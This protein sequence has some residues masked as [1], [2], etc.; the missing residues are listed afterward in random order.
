MTLTELQA[1]VMHQTNNDVDDLGD[2]TPY[3]TGYLNEGYDRLVNVYANAHAG[4]EGYP[5][6]S[7]GT[8]APQLP[9]WTHPAIANW[10]TWLIYRNGNPNKQQRGLQ[11]RAA[12]EEVSAQV[13]ASGGLAGDTARAAGEPVGQI[14]NI[15]FAPYGNSSAAAGFDPYAT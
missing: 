13:R 10:A 3:L 8:D 11:F 9:V 7:L 15:P 12:A 6:L 2:F 5:M 4:D 1:Y 14:H